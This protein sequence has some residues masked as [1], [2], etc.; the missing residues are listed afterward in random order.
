MERR[1]FLNLVPGAVLCSAGFL[2]ARP[3]TAVSGPKPFLPNPPAGF[4][5]VSTL[6]FEQFVD[7]LRGIP[8]DH[9]SIYVYLSSADQG[10]LT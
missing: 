7:E 9:D 6:K 10:D 3:D 8:R 5:P 2:L 4:T 1:A